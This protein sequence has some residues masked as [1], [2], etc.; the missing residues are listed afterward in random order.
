[1]RLEPLSLRLNV[2]LSASRECLS[3]VGV[4]LVFLVYKVVGRRDMVVAIGFE[5]SDRVLFLE[6]E[7]VD[8]TLEELPSIRHLLKTWEKAGLTLLRKRV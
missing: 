6:L 4:P 3:H 7:V 5:A 2:V 1:M 8:Q